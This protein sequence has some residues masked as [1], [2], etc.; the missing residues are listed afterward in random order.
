MVSS[1]VLHSESRSACRC[2]FSKPVA[3][4][5]L[6]FVLRDTDLFFLVIFSYFFHFTLPE[7]QS[8][9]AVAWASPG[10]H[11]FL[12]GCLR[13]TLQ[14]ESFLITC[15]ICLTSF[16]FSLTSSSWRPQAHSAMQLIWLP[17]CHAV[18]LLSCCHFSLQSSAFCINSTTKNLLAFS[19][20]A[21]LV[22]LILHL[23]S[24]CSHLFRVCVFFFSPHHAISFFNFSPNMLKLSCSVLLFFPLSPQPFTLQSLWPLQS[25]ME[26]RLDRLDDAILVLRNH[27][28]GST[29]SLPS[30]IHSLLGQ[31]QNGPIA[32]IGGN[33]PPS[34]LVA[35]RTAG[36][37]WE[38]YITINIF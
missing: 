35:S 20:Q 2:V 4:P 36:M 31:A 33:F 34:A 5:S 25:R 6:L 22:A 23:N 37:V 10:C 21:E 38:L 24:L 12:K 18:M 28:V 11:V 7:K 3:V 32:A 17:S 19:P 1:H 29:A 8:S 30:D 26:D 9:S 27:A 16:L 13:G 15:S 14:T